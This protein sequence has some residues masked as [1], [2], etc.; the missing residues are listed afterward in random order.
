VAACARQAGAPSRGRPDARLRA[1]H[2]TAPGLNRRAMTVVNAAVAARSRDR[3]R[4][5]TP[6]S[7]PSTGMER[8]QAVRDRPHR[9]PGRRAARA[10][11]V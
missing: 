7:Q 5:V 9:P 8:P 4:A 2:Q 11:E 1:A 6:C 3:H 10:D